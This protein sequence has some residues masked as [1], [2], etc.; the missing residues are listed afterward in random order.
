M[1]KNEQYDAIREIVGDSASNRDCR[2]YLNVLSKRGMTLDDIKE[3]PAEA[4]FMRL[5]FSLNKS[6]VK[7]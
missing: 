2:K 3:E 1:S 7:A 4:A 5:W 6:E